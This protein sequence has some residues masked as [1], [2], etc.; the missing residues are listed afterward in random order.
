M[1]TTSTPMLGRREE[2]WL[3]PDNGWHKANCDGAFVQGDGTRGGV[4]VIRD[5]H[6]DFLAGASRFYPPVA[7]PERAELLACHQAMT[8]AKEVG[9]TKLIL[10][11]D[12]LWSGEEVGKLGL[13]SFVPWNSC[14][15]HQHLREFDDFSVKH[16]RRSANGVPHCF[17]KGGCK[18]KICNTWLGVPPVWVVNL[19]DVV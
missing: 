13:G 18:N 2:H 5:H 6:G 19:L 12:C 1:H 17:A 14:R 9:V 10:E 15:K 16:M 7:D 3:R 4:G 11:S 8:L